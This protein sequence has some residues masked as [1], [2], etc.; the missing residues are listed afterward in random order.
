VQSQSV[1]E[2]VGAVGIRDRGALAWGGDF[3]QEE[4]NAMASGQRRQ[5][6]EDGATEEGGRRGGKKRYARLGR[7]VEGFLWAWAPSA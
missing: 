3:L 6:E 2:A 7:G 1:E 4:R 5:R